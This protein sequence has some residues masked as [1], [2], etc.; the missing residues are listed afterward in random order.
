MIDYSDYPELAAFASLLSSADPTV[1]RVGLLQIVDLADEIPAPFV[2][3]TGDRDAGVRVEAAKALEGNAA[4]E[5]IR[6]LAGLLA[7][8]DGEVAHHAAISLGEILDPAAGPVLLSQLR[9]ASGDARAVLLGALRKLRYSPALGDAV[10]LSEDASTDVRREAVGVLAYLKEAAAVPV[11]LKRLADGDAEVRRIA[12]GALVFATGADVAAAVGRALG[13]PDWQVRQ[14]AA[15]TLGKLKHSESIPALLGA[16]DD[17][18][19]EVRLKAAN[20]LGGLRAR[21]AL[22]GLIANLTHSISN[23]RKEVATALG[24]IGDPGAI[25]ALREML[26]TDRDIEVRKASQR[27]LE[28][29]AA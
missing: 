22:P 1:R 19:W 4:P 23:V 2:A 28:V 16:L 8:P 24:A 18:A 27:A 10:A 25:P 15:G 7:D 9:E 5:A 3:A 26:A 6:A 21:S 13:D 14:E 12:V 29:L 20:A 17:T 11:L